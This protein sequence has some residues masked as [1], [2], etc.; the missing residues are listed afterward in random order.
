MRVLLLKNIYLRLGQPAFYYLILLSIYSSNKE[1]RL[2]YLRSS[3]IN[4][5]K[6][7]KMGGR[8]VRTLEDKLI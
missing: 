5:L 1:L 4:F 2:L 6:L 8:T 3:F 7:R